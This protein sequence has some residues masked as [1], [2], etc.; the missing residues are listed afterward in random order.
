M[1]DTSSSRAERFK[2]GKALRRKTPREAHAHLKVPLSR[3]AVAILAE[4]DPDRVPELVPERYA[5]MSANPFAFLRGAAAVM[6]TD[7]AAQPMAGLPVQ[8]GG[9]SHLMNFGAFVTPENNILFD[10]NDFDETLPGV[11]FTV[12]LKRLAASVAV[13]A[14]G[15]DLSRKEARSLAAATVGSYRLH[16]TKLAKLSP[17]EIWHSRI[18]LEQEI[19]RIGNGDLRR[20]L[21]VVIAK[22]R[23]EGLSKDD[24]F[25][26]LVSGDTPRI[27]DKPPT[28]FH[29]DPKADAKHRLG[30]DRV[31]AAYRK[32]LN[33]AVLRLLD[34]FTLKDVAFKA[35]GVGSVGTFCC[36][37]L[38]MT[39][40]DEP[41][42]LQIKQAQASVLE[43]LGGK[44]GYKGNQGRRVVQGQQ[45][46]QAAS[47]FFLGATQ[48]DDTGRQFY[49]RTLKN[50]RLGGISELSEG[51]ALSDY[52]QLCGRTLAR[53][54]ARSGDP[55]GIA[56]YM[57]RSEAL[58]DAIASF[59]MAYA[60]QTILDHAALLKAKAPAKT[61][62]KKSTTK[63]AKAA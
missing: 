60:D 2:L 1:T 25:P 18:D 3:N 57:G 19:G 29:L 22:A 47:D 55:T 9:D 26:H 39:G 49:I 15:S 56:G 53:A 41:L 20:K 37:G 48:D 50:R 38:F 4:S 7:L 27:I 46:M 21:S 51:E 13:A 14:L 58:D 36:I 62:K 31:F 17:L 23:G 54:H 16:M 8:A 45:M 32:S 33:P 42:F 11:D 28:I 59:A 63:K 6:A 24:N 5:R 61:G 35:V 40:D 44:L 10:V 12:D 30:V 52:A 34:R 43:R